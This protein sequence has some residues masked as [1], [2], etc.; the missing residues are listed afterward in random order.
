MVSETSGGK[1]K[2]LTTDKILEGINRK[3]SELH[4][5]Q[6]SVEHIQE[7]SS[8]FEDEAA[9]LESASR[10]STQAL[11]EI[12]QPSSQPL[13]SISQQLQSNESSV[14]ELIDTTQ[15]TLPHHHEKSNPYSSAVS[16]LLKKVGSIK[17]STEIF[18]LK[19]VIVSDCGGQPPFLDAAAL[20]LQNSS[21]RI[22]PLKLSDR[23]DANAD[24]SYFVGG[25]NCLT[26]SYVP[27]TNQQTIETFA[28]SVAATQ[29]LCTPSTEGAQEGRTCRCKFTIIGTFEDQEHESESVERKE[30]ILKDVLQPYKFFQVC[31]DHFILPINAAVQ[32]GPD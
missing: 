32:P 2:K 14:N 11:T 26:D 7:L 30:E 28:K 4:N 19:W 31:G 1:W 10:V 27:L 15:P 20:F 8:S 17:H 21:L 23:L 5:Q 18:S 3:V 9:P 24:I 12:Y 25:N 13:P 29:P 6:A 22:I 16:E